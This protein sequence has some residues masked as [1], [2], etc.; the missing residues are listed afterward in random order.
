MRR[1]GGQE[2]VFARRGGWGRGRWGREGEGWLGV[3]IN[4]AGVP[5]FN[6]GLKVFLNVN[7][8]YNICLTI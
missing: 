6:L 3:G 1:G 5:I 2:V 7:A 8:K 4:T